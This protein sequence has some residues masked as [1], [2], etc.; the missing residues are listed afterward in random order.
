MR[1][2]RALLI[3]QR[4]LQE[5][6][7]NRLM[8]I[9]L[10]FTPTM[11]VLGPVPL[12][13]TM[14][15][16]AA[17]AALPIVSLWS[18]TFLMLPVIVPLAI[19]AQ[20][21]VGERERRTIE[22]LLAAPIEATEIV[23]GK[24]LAAIAP[25]LLVTWTAYGIFCLIVN[26]FL[27]PQFERGLLPDRDGLVMMFLLAPTIATLGNGMVVAVSARVSDARL[28]NQLS[29]L[30]VLPLIGVTVGPSMAGVALGP[31]FDLIAASL[32]IV[33]DVA[34]FALAVRLFDRERLISTVR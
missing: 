25:G 31:M 27:W 28:A 17:A 20:S 4:E 34:V 14:K 18:R 15:S 13:A 9:S 3:A 2:S 7:A 26:W 22:P 5:A 23:L 19:G 11:L 21:V 1:L 12:L 10:A 6:M 29:G 30:L 16:S 32:L 33:A 8:M 24:M